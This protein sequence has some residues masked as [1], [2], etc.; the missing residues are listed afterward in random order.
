M[1]K[2][3]LWFILG[4]FTQLIAILMWG[5]YVWLSKLASGG[6]GGTPFEQIQPVFWFLIITE[7]ISFTI[8]AIYFS[9]K[10]K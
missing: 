5:E 2:I 9:K 1:F 8:T 6:V 10:E 7:I 4:L 3:S